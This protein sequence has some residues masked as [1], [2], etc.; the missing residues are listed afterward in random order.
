M[1][2]GLAISKPSWDKGVVTFM[3]LMHNGILIS[4]YALLIR[5]NELN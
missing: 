1:I 5:F 4:V 3:S 2:Y